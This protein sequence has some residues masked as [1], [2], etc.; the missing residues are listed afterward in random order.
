MSAVEVVAPVW[1]IVCDR[2]GC[3]ASFT[4]PDWWSRRSDRTA[5]M[6]AEEA[7]WQVRP[8]KGRG[9]RIGPDLCPQH[10]AQT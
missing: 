6:A 2:E 7:G 3:R 9:S 1:R 10:R 5:R 8:W 4:S